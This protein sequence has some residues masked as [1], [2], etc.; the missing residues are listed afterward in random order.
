MGLGGRQGSMTCGNFIGG[1]RS[2]DSDN[3][4]TWNAP[5]R[6]AQITNINT[7]L[8]ASQEALCIPSI[9]SA[10]QN[11][12]PKSTWSCETNLNTDSGRENATFNQKRG[13]S[14]SHYLQAHFAA[15]ARLFCMM[16][17]LNKAIASPNPANTCH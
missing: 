16:L 15:T 8:Q 10:P 17:V 7:D 14:E 11:I 12:M 5:S 4:E 6:W 2:D 1:V 13:S 9:D 3:L